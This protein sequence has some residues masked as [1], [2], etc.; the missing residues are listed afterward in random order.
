RR[1]EP[2]VAASNAL[3]ER[4]AELELGGGLVDFIDDQRVRGANVVVLEP[5]PRYAGSDDYDVPRR[6]FRS[7]LALAVHDAYAEIFRLE[8]RLGDRPDRERLAGSG[9]GDDPEPRAALGQSLNLRTVLTLEH[10]LQM[11]RQRQ[12]DR[13]AG[14]A[15]GCDD[16]HPPI[17][18]L[19]SHERFV[20]RRQVAVMDRARRGHYMEDIM[21]LRLGSR[22][23]RPLD[24][25]VA[26]GRHRGEIIVQSGQ[27]ITLERRAI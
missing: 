19:G 26:D 5:A 17:G 9:A 25:G 18:R 16:D 23:V 7:R 12:L 21:I 6:R 4:E 8:D 14:R 11:E 13:L 20:V 27:R 10:S 15:R 3:A 1:G 2:D 24:R 22:S